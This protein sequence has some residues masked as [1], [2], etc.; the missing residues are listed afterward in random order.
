[1]SAI[2]S[3]CIG[4]EKVGPA[5]ATVNAAVCDKNNCT[6]TVQIAEVPDLLAKPDALKQLRAVKGDQECGKPTAG[7][8]VQP[9][10]VKGGGQKPPPVG[11]SAGRGG[12]QTHPAK[13]HFKHGGK[14][15]GK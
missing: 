10:I 4:D 14:T 7:A 8:G 9:P 11:P 2:P 6:I 3:I 12:G 15:K 5:N 1:M 13:K